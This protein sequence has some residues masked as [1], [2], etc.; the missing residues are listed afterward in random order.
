MNRGT[1]RSRDL[2]PSC[3]KKTM[4]TCFNE[5]VD[6]LSYSTPSIVLTQYFGCCRSRS[7]PSGS[8]MSIHAESNLEVIVTV[9]NPDG[10]ILIAPQA[11]SI[12]LQSDWSFHVIVFLQC[13]E[14]WGSWPFKRVCP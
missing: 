8:G 3:R 1:A 12:A 14:A 2:L 13:V 4:N 9:W 7:M 6:V 10:I 5:D 11:V